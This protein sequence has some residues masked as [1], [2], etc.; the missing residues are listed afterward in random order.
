MR[1]GSRQSRH[2][3]KFRWFYDMNADPLLKPI[4]KQILGALA[5]KKGDEVDLVTSPRLKALA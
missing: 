1:R 5:L 3:T 2:S 4:V